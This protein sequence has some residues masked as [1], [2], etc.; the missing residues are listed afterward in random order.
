M[1]KCPGNGRVHAADC[2]AAGGVAPRTKQQVNVLGGG[3][4]VALGVERI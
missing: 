2:E 1:T 3:N 4:G